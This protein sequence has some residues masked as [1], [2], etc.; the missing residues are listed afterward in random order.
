MPNDGPNLMATKIK[1]TESAGGGAGLQLLGVV[2][3]VVGFFLGAIGLVFFGGLG[4]VL[5][6]YGG[7]KANVLKCSDCMGKVEKQARVC[8]HCRADLR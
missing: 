1:K 2:L 7:I 6:I 4:L 8:P 5:L 3:I